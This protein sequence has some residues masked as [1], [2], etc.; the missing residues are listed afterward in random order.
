M[1]NCFQSGKWLT[2]PLTLTLSR[3]GRED[4]EGSP[5]PRGER[6]FA[7]ASMWRGFTNSLP[8][9]G[10]RTS[11]EPYHSSTPPIPLRQWEGNFFLFSLHGKYFMLSRPSTGELFLLSSPLM[12]EEKGEGECP[13][14]SNSLPQRGE[15]IAPSPNLS[16][17]GERDKKVA[18]SP[19]GDRG[20]FCCVSPV[21]PNGLSQSMPAFV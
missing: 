6:G 15:R 12:G 14:H 4:K 3:E 11:M 9:R 18:L 13:P 2:N 8:R 20:A 7:R 5:L 21:H 10:E 19:L 16:R 1:V 17:G